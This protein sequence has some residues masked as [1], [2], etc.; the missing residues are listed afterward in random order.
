MPHRVASTTTR[1]SLF[2]NRPSYGTATM[3]WLVKQHTQM[4]FS[5]TRLSPARY[6]VILLFHGYKSNGNT[7]VSETVSSTSYHPQ[8]FTQIP[9]KTNNTEVLSLII[10]QMKINWQDSMWILNLT[11]TNHKRLMSQRWS[12]TIHWILHTAHQ[13][14]KTIEYVVPSLQLQFKID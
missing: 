14:T 11:S 12:W 13:T 9:M 8:K 7:N 4:S 1:C 3:N 10:T 2:T 5:S 6:T